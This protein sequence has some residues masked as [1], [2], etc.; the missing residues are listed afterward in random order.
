MSP[1]MS[2]TMNPIPYHRPHDIAEALRLFREHPEARFIAGGTDLMVQMLDRKVTPDQLISLRGIEKLRRVEV[3]DGAI[4]GAACPV[5]DLLENTSLCARWPVLATAML[6]LGSVQIRSSATLGGNICNASPAADTATPLLALDAVVHIE[7]DHGTRT[8][9]L[10]E[11]FVA[12]GK[13][14][15]GSKGIV[16]AIE[17]PPPATNLRCV[18]QKKKRVAMDIALVNLACAAVLEEGVL[19]QVRIAA[20]SVAPTP[21]RL[22]KAEEVLEG[23]AVT[24]ERVALAREA[25]EKEITPIS[26]IRAGAEYRRAI[27]GVFLE[28]ALAQLREGEQ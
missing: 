21:M 24:A 28:R 11:F 26:D 9:A 15:C 5:V 18:F 7:D 3:A 14:A 17:L 2:T 27:V 20:G 23:H 25:A 22:R 13:T 4:I 16:T 8:L 1:E 12:P 19:K 6:E 10:D